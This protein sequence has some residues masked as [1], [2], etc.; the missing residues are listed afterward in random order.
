MTRIVIV[1]YGAGNVES[2][3]NAI[4]MAGFD[5]VVSSEPEDVLAAD[6]LVL[7]GVGA[8][9]WALERLRGC[10]LYDAIEE[11][12]VEKGRPMLGICLG[13]QLL[14][15][16]LHEFGC[17]QGFGWIDG[18]VIPLK[19]M[20]AD[21]ATVPHMGWNHVEPCENAEGMVAEGLAMGGFFYFAHSYILRPYDETVVVA[22]VDYGI[23]LVAAVRW[24]TVFAV[25]FHPEKSQDDGQR[26]LSAFF[27][28]KP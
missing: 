25:Q 4:Y 21:G 17:H 14:A 15:G 23:P 27:G 10:G 9:G 2:V 11:A 20:I 7:P 8:A 19:K 24:Q 16:T 13:M 6:R 12:V 3:R 26:L 28:W 5:P 1:D 22:T 18:S